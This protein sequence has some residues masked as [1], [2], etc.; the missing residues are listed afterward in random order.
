MLTPGY[1]LT[2]DM[3]WTPTVPLVWSSDAFNN[4]FILQ[5]LLY[6][7]SLII[8]SWLVQKMILLMIFFL[9]LY[10]PWR[11]LPLISSGA[12]R[13]C[14]AMLYALNPFVYSRMLAGQW[15]VLLG[16]ALLPL[17]VYALVQL[18]KKPGPRS[19]VLF[20]GALWLISL[21]TIH[22]V[23][24]SLLFSLFFVNT[25]AGLQ[26]GRKTYDAAGRMVKWTGLGVV[27]FL[28][29]SMY[30]MVPAL[31]RHAP[32][33][34]EF[35]ERHFSAFAAAQN[36]STS[37]MLNVAALG[38]FWGEQQAWRYYFVWPQDTWL[39]WITAF[40]LALIAMYGMYRGIHDPDT[41][42]LTVFLFCIGILTYI[43]ALGTADTPFRS[44]NLLL[45]QHF[46][47]WSGLRDSHKIAAFLS[48]AYVL[49][50]GMGFASIFAYFEKRRARPFVIAFALLLPMLFGMYQWNGFHG[51]LTPVWYPE[52]WHQAKMVLD[53]ALPEE[54][55]LVL[56]W[57]QYSSLPFAHQLLVANPAPDF[58]GRDRMIVARNV[59]IGGIY[60]QE[61]DDAY[62]AIDTLVEHASQ[63]PQQALLEALQ[64]QNI[65]YILY[66]ENLAATTSDAQDANLHALISLPSEAMHW[67][68]ISLLRLKEK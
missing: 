57:H 66:I 50:A 14:A 30:W 27:A 56:P 41:H 46:P 43:T 49:L 51:Q 13:V 26:V 55:V 1:I 3:P 44:F 15:T 35:D 65:H 62:R 37:V 16:Y 9:L 6:V 2:L 18:T 40:I 11:F 63:Y 21:G 53:Q 29:V 48:L 59:E 7:F 58:F 60:H 25:Y 33:E 10:V 39:F 32:L 28:L 34:G 38:G 20:A 68:D 61:N 5:A 8:P 17:L 23:Y 45:Y 52:S 24:L 64:K 31:I 47:G 19:M 12:A 67:D 4:T 36:E 22:F 42:F 54:K